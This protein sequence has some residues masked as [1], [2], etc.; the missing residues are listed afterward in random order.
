MFVFPPLAFLATSW[1]VR[2]WRL[3]WLAGA[4]ALLGSTL[5]A[6]S[7]WSTLQDKPWEPLERKRTWCLNIFEYICSFWPTPFLLPK[8]R[9]KVKDQLWIVFQLRSLSL[10]I[11]VSGMF[12]SFQNECTNMWSQ[13]EQWDHISWWGFGRLKDTWSDCKI[14]P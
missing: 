7:F 3:Q 2:P 8:R 6:V 1:H 11:L 4:L 13:V 14:S 12:S 10:Q 5:G 9:V